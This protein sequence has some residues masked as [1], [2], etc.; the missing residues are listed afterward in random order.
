MTDIT[1]L[2]HAWHAAQDAGDLDAAQTAHVA[3]LLAEGAGH[4]FLLELAHAMIVLIYGKEALDVHQPAGDVASGVQPTSTAPQTPAPAEPAA[5]VA[6]VGDVEGEAAA[7]DVE[8]ADAAQN[9]ASAESLSGVVRFWDAQRGYGYI[10]AADGHD[11][12]AQT[13]NL[14]Y[15]SMPITRGMVVTFQPIPSAAENAGMPRAGRIWDGVYTPPAAAPYTAP[16]SVVTAARD[17][18]TR[19]RVNRRRARD[20]RRQQDDANRQAMRDLFNQKN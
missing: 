10:R 1:T 6:G 12:Y 11:Y 17:V 13:R 7:Q 5:H 19:E 9:S 18:N 20:D 16:S 15:V 4:P 2:K 14:R 3:Y 8:A